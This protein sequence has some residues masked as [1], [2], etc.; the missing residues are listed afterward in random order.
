MF[1]PTGGTSPVQQKDDG[2][3]MTIETITD[4][5]C[6]ASHF[7]HNEKQRE[8]LL[9]MQSHG[10]PKLTSHLIW[11]TP[12]AS[13]QISPPLVFWGRDWALLAQFN[14]EKRIRSDYNM[15]ERSE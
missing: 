4:C 8:L 15:H 11:N 5:K 1:K 2:I 10:G 13:L 6:D 3:V 12:H 9:L 14:N 7:T